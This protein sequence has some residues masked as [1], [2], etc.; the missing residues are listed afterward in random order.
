MDW[1]GHKEEAAFIGRLFTTLLSSRVNTVSWLLVL[2]RTA[3]VYVNDTISL[4]S[5]ELYPRSAFATSAAHCQSFIGNDVRRSTFSPQNKWRHT[6]SVSPCHFCSLIRATWHRRR[7]TAGLS[8]Q[9]FILLLVEK[10]DELTVRYYKNLKGISGSGT[11]SLS[12]VIWTERPLLLLIIPA[13]F[14][15]LQ[16]PRL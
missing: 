6:H 14:V 11:L 1:L 12:G 15:A 13:A 4:S 16:T 3:T 8:A 9:P 10:L 7:C 2:A 5:F